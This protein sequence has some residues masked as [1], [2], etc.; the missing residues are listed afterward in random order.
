VV[1]W[2]EKR[3]Q[4]SRHSGALLFLPP[5]P[6][7]PPHNTPA[8]VIP[9]V[10]YHPAAAVCVVGPYRIQHGM[11]RYSVA[12]PYGI[13][14]RRNCVFFF[15]GG[16]RTGSY[17]NTVYYVVPYGNLFRTVNLIREIALR[18]A[19][20]IHI[21]LCPY[22]Y[23]HQHYVVGGTSTARQQLKT[24]MVAAIAL[25]WSNR[26]NPAICH[27]PHSYRRATGRGVPLELKLYNAV[28]VMVQVI[29]NRQMA[30]PSFSC[31][32]CRG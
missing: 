2:H 28:L 3:A 10:L 23:P 32:A 31:R 16:G 30:L 15:F 13:H 24:G 20:I 25:F 14:N 5:P 29:G 12:A 6:T 9:L 21:P 18:R 17:R 26:P 22:G 7:V 8:A 11:P 19:A 27:M 1:E 4:G